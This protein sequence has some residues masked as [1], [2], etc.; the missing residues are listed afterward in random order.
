MRSATPRAKPYA[1]KKTSTIRAVI[2]DLGRVLVDVDTARLARNVFGRDDVTDTQKA[3]HHIM[4]DDLVQAFHAGSIEPEAFWRRLTDRLGVKMSFSRFTLAWCDI[5]SPMPESERVVREL[6]PR[7]KLGLLSDT[8][9]LHWQYL[10]EHYSFLRAFQR[11][12]LSFEVGATKP[13]PRVF[14]AAVRNVGVPPAECLYIDDLAAN[15]EGARRSG[16][17]AMQF[18]SAQQ[19]R[20]VLVERNLL[21]R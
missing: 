21:V 10:R 17:D 11:P 2:F 5:F 6:A 14:S 7:V 20:D 4:A 3:I 9:P 16:L 12:T 8:D 19:L 1:M 18:I 15:V 13:D